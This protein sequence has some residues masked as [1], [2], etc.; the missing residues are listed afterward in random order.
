MSQYPYESQ[1]AWIDGRTA[2]TAERERTFLRSVYGWMFGGLLLTAAAALWV[3][4]SPALQQLIFT[5]PLRWVLLFGELG[6]VFY[7]SFRITKMSA[8]TA[9]SVFLVFSLLN[10]LTLSV[11]FFAYTTAAIYQA[12]F[13]AAGMFGA[14]SVY[15]M[16]TKRD[17]TSWGSFFFMGLIGIV[18]ASIVNIFLKSPAF[19]W[20]ISII[21]VFVFLGLTAYDTQKLKAYASSPQLRENLA[22]Y[23]ALAL[24]LDF[25]NLFLMLLRLFGGGNNRR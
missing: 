7:L 22:I 14:M 21:G 20:A 17:L 8:A 1:P 4:M 23:G 10:G 15:G 18:I 16:V 3:V 12:F 24:Y 6:L 5:T 11:I 9:A 2:Q 19:A 13:T 25:V